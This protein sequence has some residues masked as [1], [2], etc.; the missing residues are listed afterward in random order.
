MVLQHILRVNKLLMTADEVC[1]SVGQ[2]EV[3]MMSV[4]YPQYLKI[5]NIDIQ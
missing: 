3:E 5:A 1:H 2:E 4:F